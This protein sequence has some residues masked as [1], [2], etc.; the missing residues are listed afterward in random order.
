MTATNSGCGAGAGVL[1]SEPM[2]LPRGPCLL[3]FC[4]A[5]PRFEEAF[6]AELRGLGA[7]LLALTPSTG[8]LF[9]A[10]DEPRA[11]GPQPELWRL[12]GAGGA[13]LTVVLL[14][15]GHRVRLRREAPEAEGTL[16]A[17]VRSAGRAV[18]SAPR[19]MGRRDLLVNSLAV[20]LGAAV[21]QA[22]AASRPIGGQQES[23]AAPVLLDVTLVVNGQRRALRVEPRVVLLDALRE[24]LGLTGAKK[25]CDMGQCGACT[26]LVDGQRVNSCLKLVAQLDGASVTTIEGLARGDELHPMQQAF[27]QR[28]A[29]QCG[30]C[31]PGQILSAVALLREGRPGDDDEI[32]ERMSG[33]LCRCG[34]YPNILAAIKD[35]AGSV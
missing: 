18:R 14:D 29:L 35:V 27:I 1:P 8:T 33:N 24:N 31:T 3:A 12:H 28:D 25:G 32:R 5:P 21:L 7:P 20:A 9:G 22:C 16:L 23:G 10:D 2:D 11:V 13:A 6:R 4:A 26:V 30:Y 19:G 34:A 15:E 17:A